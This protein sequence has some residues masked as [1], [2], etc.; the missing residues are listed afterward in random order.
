MDPNSAAENLQVIRTLMERSALYRRALA[1]VMLAAGVLGVAGGFVG[2]R[3]DLRYTGFVVF[4]FT[5]AVLVIGISL[6]IVR[7][8]ALS[9]QEPFWTP[10]TRQVIR[11]MTPPL[12]AGFLIVFSPSVGGFH[13]VDPASVVLIWT[14]LYGCAL[15]SAGLFVSR[16]VRL[17]GW[18]FILTSLAICYMKLDLNARMAMDIPLGQA[19]VGVQ[20]ILLRAHALMGLTF[21][22]LHLIAAVYLYVTEKRKNA[23]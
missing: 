19:A 8:Q 5:I 1:P 10:P 21:G 13:T 16:G 6:L 4:W 11:A 15:H 20:S 18:I 2:D 9:S 12:T 22:G 23:Q 7:R 14:M 17:L 3:F